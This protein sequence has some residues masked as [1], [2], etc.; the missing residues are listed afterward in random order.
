MPGRKPL[1]PSAYNV[2]TFKFPV[3]E[4]ESKVSVDN[5]DSKIIPTFSCPSAYP[6]P[7]R[8]SLMKQHDQWTI[9]LIGAHKGGALKSNIVSNWYWWPLRSSLLSFNIFIVHNC[10]LLCFLSL[11]VHIAF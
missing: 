8:K 9:R 2:S 4:L 1:P 10:A 3:G 5:L 11:F 7:L 6:E